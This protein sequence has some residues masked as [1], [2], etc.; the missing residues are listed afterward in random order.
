MSFFVAFQKQ[1]PVGCSQ[2]NLDHGKLGETNDLVSSTKNAVRES[3]GWNEAFVPKEICHCVMG[4]QPGTRGHSPSEHDLPETAKVRDRSKTSRC[5]GWGLGSASCEGACGGASW[6]RNVLGYLDC[7]TG[8]AT[9]HTCQD[10]S[11]C[12]LHKGECT[13]QKP[14]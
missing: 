8:Y 2:L 1:P 7:N 5:Q 13:W 12:A 6:V 10:S 4:K 14:A 11:N 3:Q 9:A